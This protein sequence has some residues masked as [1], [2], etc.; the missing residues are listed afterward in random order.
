MAESKPAT[1]TPA[2]SD[3]PTSPADLPDIIG[4]SVHYST[5]KEVDLPDT[6]AAVI[7][8]VEKGVKDEPD[9]FGVHVFTAGW[10]GSILGVQFSEEPKA[11]HWSWPPRA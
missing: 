7:I 4:R 5:A 1:T 9:T 3:A 6:C 8:S 11:G 10:D 2:S